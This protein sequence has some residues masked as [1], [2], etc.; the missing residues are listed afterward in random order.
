MHDYCTWLNIL[1]LHSVF[2]YVFL[3]FFLIVKKRMIPTVVFLFIAVFAVWALGNTIGTV[4]QF[5]GCVGSNSIA[6]LIP[7]TLYILNIYRLKSWNKYTLASAVLFLIVY[8][9]VLIGGLIEM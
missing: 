7:G 8:F 5:I 6:W 4:V 3:Y 2:L 9:F 1:I